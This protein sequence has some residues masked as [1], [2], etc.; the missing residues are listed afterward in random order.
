MNTRAQY[1][2]FPAKH[3]KIQI[4]LQILKK[5]WTIMKRIG[6]IGL[7]T[8]GAPMAANLL[9]AGYEVT[10]YNR[11]ASKCSPLVSQGAKQAASP[12]EAAASTDIVIT[13]V[14]NDQSI[15]RNNFV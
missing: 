3:V 10:V 9:K 6:F 8:M 12:K 14:S 4:C 2:P 13:M 5:R 1:A 15:E 11:T 7:G